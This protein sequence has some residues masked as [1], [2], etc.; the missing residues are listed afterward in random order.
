L[1]VGFVVN[2]SDSKSLLIRGTGP[3][4]TEFGVTGALAD[5]VLSLY[6]GASLLSTNDDWSFSADATA[7]APLSRTL[8]AFALPDASHDAALITTLDAGAYTAHVNGN[9][10]S[11]GVALIELYDAAPGTSARLVNVSVRTV[12]NATNTPIIGFVVDGNAPKRL[13]VRAIGPGLATF[14]VTQLLADPQL[15]IFNGSTSLQKNDNWSGS[16]DLESAFEQVG[17]FPLNDTQSKDAAAIF[18]AAPGAYTVV[19][20]GAN[21]TSGTVLL[22]VYELP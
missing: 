13:L 17:A 11:E 1:I 19:V 18:T 22:E 6:A 4:L 9:N 5:P 15:E 8:G 14:G 7:I 3:A 20:T 16:S 21:N 10:G 2:G 12:V